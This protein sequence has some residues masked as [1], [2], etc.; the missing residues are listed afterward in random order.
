MKNF[1]LNACGVQEM[2]SLEIVNANGGQLVEFALYAFEEY[3]SNFGTIFGDYMS[4]C[5]GGT[6][7]N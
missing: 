3:C 6:Y 7:N 5:A 1:D 2:N 4:A